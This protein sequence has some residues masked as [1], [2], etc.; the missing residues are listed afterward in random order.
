MDD[1]TIPEKEK[2]SREEL[3]KLMRENPNL[4]VVPMV[5]TEIV[6]GDD[7]G[8]WLGCW[9]DSHIGEYIIGKEKVYFRDDNDA[10]DAQDLLLE[11]GWNYEIVAPMSAKEIIAAYDTLPWIKAIIVNIDLP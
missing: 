9:G 1:S 7:Y 5:A 3:F 4:P 6:A 10:Q 8:R 11:K 2:A